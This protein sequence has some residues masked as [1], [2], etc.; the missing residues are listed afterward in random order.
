MPVDVT[1]VPVGPEHILLLWNSNGSGSHSGSRNGRGEAFPGSANQGTAGAV[2]IGDVTRL[3]LETGGGQT[4]APGGG[5]CGRGGVKSPSSEV[6]TV[7]AFSPPLHLPASFLEGGSTANGGRAVNRAGV[8]AGGAAKLFPAVAEGLASADAA[9]A[10]S[11][12][13]LSPRAG[14]RA[15]RGVGGDDRGGGGAGEGWADG[16]DVGQ[17]SRGERGGDD[18][19]EDDHK[20]VTERPDSFIAPESMKTP[21]RIQAAGRSPAPALSPA[22]VRRLTNA[23]LRRSTSGTGSSRPLSFRSPPAIP[24]IEHWGLRGGAR[25]GPRRLGAQGTL[26]QEPSP[27]ATAAAA[28]VLEFESAGGG[29][30]EACNGGP[31]AR[32]TAGT[33]V[34]PSEEE[35]ARHRRPLSDRRGD[36]GAPLE[37]G[38]RKE[39][40]VRQ[41]L[42]ESRLGGSLP[43]DNS[44]SSG[45]GDIGGPSPPG[46]GGRYGAAEGGG[47]D[48]TARCG[49][50]GGGRGDSGGSGGNGSGDGSGS[51]GT[52]GGEPTEAWAGLVMVDAAV[53][54]DSVAVTTVVAPAVAPDG[55]A[56]GDRRAMPSEERTTRVSTAAYLSAA[57]T[58][59]PQQQPLSSSAM[60]VP[61]HNRV[62]SSAPGPSGPTAA[63][64]AAP[65]ATMAGFSTTRQLHAVFSPSFRPA[66]TAPAPESETGLTAMAHGRPA[67][68]RGAERG[69]GD[70]RLPAWDRMAIICAHVAAGGGG[71]T[72][73]GHDSIGDSSRTSSSATNPASAAAAAE[74]EAKLGDIETGMSL[75]PDHSGGGGRSGS[76]GD[77]SGGENTA[78]GLLSSGERGARAACGTGRTAMMTKGIVLSQ[79]LSA[80]ALSG[81]AEDTPPLL[82]SEPCRSL[83]RAPFR[84]F[85]PIPQSVRCM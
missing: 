39:G 46:G 48:L 18:G 14:V 29:G 7:V 1:R 47:E 23:F 85:L 37:R 35:E 38:D 27:A 6:V 31:V 36:D 21:R 67:A 63:V 5:C 83:S 66:A 42:R 26:E 13:C 50:G 52:H 11:G 2:G 45:A 25:G 76:G 55:G 4:T 22:S 33:T 58:S 57:A 73:T 79:G 77:G 54:S 28:R 51:D 82:V 61:V 74:E 44:A 75:A 3:L 30:A 12:V 15:A 49:D 84:E 68:A 9:A 20:G 41:G 69:T 80:A 65:P 19:N 59:P 81:L 56:D 8:A 40:P 72:T 10:S 17:R 53:D 62:R 71:G 16:V 34:R 60:I 64:A 24:R 78:P 70:G 32:G 43:P